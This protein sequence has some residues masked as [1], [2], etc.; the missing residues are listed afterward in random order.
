MIVAE[1]IQGE[2]AARNI[3][4]AALA[5]KANIN[6]TGV[7]DI[8]SGKSRSPRLDTIQKIADAL[9]V[10]V[11]ALFERKS[12]S[13]LAA[14]LLEIARQLPEDEQHKLILTARAWQSSLEA[15]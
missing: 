14:D 10:S 7:Y 15:S 3:T 1:N 11:S 12:T 4:A 5:R 6:A 13:A 8:I 2:M 9:D